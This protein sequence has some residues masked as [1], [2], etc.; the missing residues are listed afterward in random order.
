MSF[1]QSAGHG[2]VKGSALTSRDRIAVGGKRLPDTTKRY[3]DLW[4][5]YRAV[6]ATV[7]R[8]A[9][10]NAFDTLVTAAPIS[11][12]DRLQLV[13]KLEGVVLSVEAETF[14]ARLTDD[15]AEQPEI[16]ARVYIKEVS[17]ADRELLRPNGLFYW[18][19]G[20]RDTPDG[21]RLRESRIRFRRLPGWREEDLNNADAWADETRQLL[22]WNKPV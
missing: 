1:D 16:E 11:G 4:N 13:S 15:S 14:L 5:A 17:E 6:R 21:D 10:H 3:L 19:I 9:A 7:E 20:Y 12:S 2:Y 8:G 18:T 22:G